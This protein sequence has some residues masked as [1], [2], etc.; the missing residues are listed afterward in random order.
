MKLTGR[1]PGF[2][3]PALMVCAGLYYF[4]SATL[5]TNEIGTVDGGRG[6]GA[7]RVYDGN[8]MMPQR[9]EVD[10]QL[11]DTVRLRKGLLRAQLDFLESIR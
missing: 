6:L 8:V 1:S 11:A 5:A 3:L 9:R 10:D 2:L 7:N 4:S